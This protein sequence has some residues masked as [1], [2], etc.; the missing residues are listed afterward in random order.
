M[1]PEERQNP[2]L[3]E[4]EVGL[5]KI[6]NRTRTGKLV[7]AATGQSPARRGSVADH[8]RRPN[9]TVHLYTSPQFL[10]S[11]SIS[12]FQVITLYP[13]DLMTDTFFILLLTLALELTL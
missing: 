6:P 3:S 10:S 2:P 8:R 7:Q 4:R 11:H 5:P 12:W 13:F 1:N 9:Q